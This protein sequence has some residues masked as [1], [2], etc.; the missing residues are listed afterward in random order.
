MRGE[1]AEIKIQLVN[2]DAM[3]K[4]SG[5]VVKM[6]AQAGPTIPQKL[7]AVKKVSEMQGPIKKPP[8]PTSGVPPNA[9]T[10]SCM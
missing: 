5:Q 4:L 9:P 1:V 7:R 10:T 6:Q 2:M 8:L 3:D